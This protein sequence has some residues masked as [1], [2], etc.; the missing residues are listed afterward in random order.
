MN[1]SNV[2]DLADK[3]REFFHELTQKYEFCFSLIGNEVRPDD[4]EIV[5]SL[6][7]TFPLGEGE[8]LVYLCGYYFDE[9]DENS[10][11]CWFLVTNS[12]IYCDSYE[13]LVVDLDEISDITVENNQLCLYF[14]RDGESHKWELAPEWITGDADAEMN[15]W[16]NLLLSF[17][18]ASKKQ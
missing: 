1:R 4:L 6:I 7:G 14:D 13:D 18:E 8:K 11:S 17:V 3:N 15:P 2:L 10:E 16:K 12:S 5:E 9:K